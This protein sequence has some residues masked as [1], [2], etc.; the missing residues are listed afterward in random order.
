MGT[1]IPVTA[2][3]I[4]RENRILIAQRKAGGHQ[5][6][7]WEFPGGKVQFGERPE[8]ALRREI[9]EE[10]GLE[11]TVNQLFSVESHVYGERHI[12]LLVYWCTPAAGQEPSV[13]DVGAFTWVTPA[14]MAEYAFAPADVPI[15]G[16]LQGFAG[17]G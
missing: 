13:I 9:Q 10:L 6:L 16:K 17:R 3:L 12:L 1:I 14:A 5:E 11:I 8:E 4:R 7:L 2:A 15:V